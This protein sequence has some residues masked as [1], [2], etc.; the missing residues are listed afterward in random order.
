MLVAAR[1]YVKRVELGVKIIGTRFSSCHHIDSPRPRRR[2]HD[3]RRACDSVLWVDVMA[4]DV[5]PVLRC[6]KANVPDLLQGIDVE[7][8][9]AVMFRCDDEQIVRAVSWNIVLTNEQRLGEYVPGDLQGS[10]KAKVARNVR[11]I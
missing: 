1:A 9:H 5:A 7:G 8:I 2:A 10:Q 4:S 3:H 11:C 6:S